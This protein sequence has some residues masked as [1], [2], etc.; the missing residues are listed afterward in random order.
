MLMSGLLLKDWYVLTK[1][2][3][4]MLLI[5][6]IFACIPGLSMA[7]FAV[8]YAAMLPVTALAYDE[9]SKWN[10]LAVMMPYS[11]KELVASKYLL[12][13]ISVVT[14]SVIAFA[15]QLALCAVRGEAFSAEAAIT[16]LFTSCLA[17]TLLA[18]NLPVMFRIGVEKGRIAFMIL[19]C[20]GV[21]AGMAL[22]DKLTAALGKLV[23]IAF[24][25]VA[26]VLV[27]AVAY[28]LSIQISADMYKNGRVR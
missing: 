2:L 17:L 12:G 20:G 15:A 22:G 7:S 1:Q 23:N 9:R 21:A 19:L 3:K 4:I 14:A 5:L 8:L 26:I 27:T 13:L 6:I 10:E 24:P 28:L 11:P 25:A 16:L 18:I